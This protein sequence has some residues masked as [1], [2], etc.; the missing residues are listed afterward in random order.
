M[1]KQDVTTRFSYND[2]IVIEK[3]ECKK[4]VESTWRRAFQP[5]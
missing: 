2:E 3:E 1:N 4:K 5:Q